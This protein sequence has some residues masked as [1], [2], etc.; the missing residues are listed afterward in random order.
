MGFWSSRELKKFPS[1]SKVLPTEINWQS[2]AI[3]T[4]FYCQGSLQGYELNLDSIRWPFTLSQL[5]SSVPTQILSRTLFSRSHTYMKHVQLWKTCVLW[6]ETHLNI[7]IGNPNNTVLWK[8][9]LATEDGPW[10]SIVVLENDSLDKQ[11]MILCICPGDR[12]IRCSA[13]ELS[14][15][16]LWDNTSHWTWSYDDGQ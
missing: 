7:I 12:D 14:A 1:F 10:N 5:F 15:L 11:R 16:F 9:C 3:A 6:D 4:I 13:L 8:M 2:C